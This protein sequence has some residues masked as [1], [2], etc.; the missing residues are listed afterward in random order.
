VPAFWEGV[1]EDKIDELYPSYREAAQ[2]FVDEL[3]EYAETL[4]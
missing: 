1:P 3:R 4:V 2:K